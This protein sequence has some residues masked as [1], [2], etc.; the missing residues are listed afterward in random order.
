MAKTLKE[1]QVRSQ[2]PGNLD[3]KKQLI[4]EVREVL[5]KL[6][7]LRPFNEESFKEILENFVLK[8]K[9]PQPW[10]IVSGIEYKEGTPEYYM[11]QINK[12][13]YG[14][15]GPKIKNIRFTKPQLER[16]VKTMGFNSLEEFFTL[17]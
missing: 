1:A 2:A 9:S 16:L 4:K 13:Y 15:K 5:A 10:S 17:S 14:N 8:N 3:A 7:Q 12:I 11:K 6:C